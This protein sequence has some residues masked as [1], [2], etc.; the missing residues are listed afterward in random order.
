MLYGYWTDLKK[1]FTIRKLKAGYDMGYFIL[2]FKWVR[3][4][5]GLNR[6]V[7]LVYYIIYNIKQLVVKIMQDSFKGEGLL[8]N[9]KYINHNYALE[10]SYRKGTKWK[11]NGKS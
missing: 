1:Y 10:V 6:D 2:E 4:L 3:E 5:R 8:K 9:T 11:L 7:L